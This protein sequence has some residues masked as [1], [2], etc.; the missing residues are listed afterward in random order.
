[1]AKRIVQER[2]CSVEGCDSKHFGRGY[3]S[4]HY[5]RFRRH[6]C[7]SGGRSFVRGEPQK[8]VDTHLDHKGNGCLIWP[9]GRY[10]SGYGFVVY[11]GK[12]Y[13]ASR[14]ICE[15]SNGPAPSDAHEAAHSCG[16]GHEGC[17][18]PRH[19]RWA[20]SQENSQDAIDHGAVPKGSRHHNS[21]LTASKVLEIRGLR[22]SVN[23]HDV[24][25]RY[26]ITF[27]TVC[28][29]WSRRTWAWLE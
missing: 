4:I 27:G 11:R 1:M 22:G 2:K 23:C 21:K 10:K 6:G 28:D 3:C 24:A 14:L 7:P 20:T 13:T 8:W 5:G 19:L 25:D 12:K 9:F 18:N 29:I 17:V 16:K 15:L 26:G